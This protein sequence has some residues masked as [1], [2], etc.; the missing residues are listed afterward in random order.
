[1]WILHRSGQHLVLPLGL[2]DRHCDESNEKRRRRER[3]DRG[4]KEMKK[5]FH[6]RGGSLCW[7]VCTGKAVLSMVCAY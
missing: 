4:G 5:M 3:Q 2:E 6:E 1:V 7:N